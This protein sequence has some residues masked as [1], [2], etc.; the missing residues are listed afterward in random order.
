MTKSRNLISSLL[1]TYLDSIY[2][3]QGRER[4]LA[5]ESAMDYNPT[6]RLLDCGC[7]EGDGT[8]RLGKR[9]GTKKLIGLDHN[10]E[11]LSQATSRGILSLQV[12][13]N[14]SIP[15]SDDS[16]DVV[17]ASDVLEHLIDPFVFVGELYRV[18]RPGGYMVLDTPNL[19]SWHNI[20]ALLIGVQPFSGPNIT[21][22]EDA[23]IEL[24]RD[25][26]RSD[27]GSP[28]EKSYEIRKKHELNR[29]IV[30][31]AFFSLI[32]LIRRWGF[33]ISSVQGFGY[34]PFPPFLARLFQSIDPRHAHHILVKANKPL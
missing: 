23:D 33:E 31:V 7:R 3:V 12:D 6:A 21:T 13:L 17:V 11:V 22:M 28:K 16:V 24:V 5:Q 32:R 26:H 29:H 25:M 27:Q 4:R 1:R 8:L 34:Y 20:F 2:Y 10:R 9:V 14:R 19:A 15:L 30:V 18:L